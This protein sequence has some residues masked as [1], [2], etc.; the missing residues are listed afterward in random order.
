MVV[1]NWRRACHNPATR[2][3]HCTITDPIIPEVKF[4][5][6]TV[7]RNRK[8]PAVLK[9]RSI[10]PEF[11]TAELPVLSSNVTLCEPTPA[12]IHVT[13]EPLVTVTVP[14]S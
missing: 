7:Q 11:W 5:E 3:C 2:T 13:V 10:S 14:G 1:R 9:V 12:H 6:C 4:P 8:V